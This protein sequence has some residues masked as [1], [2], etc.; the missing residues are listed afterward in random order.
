MGP[1]T[2]KGDCAGMA[3]RGEEPVGFFKALML[4]SP[5]AF[6]SASLEQ[7]C[8]VFRAQQVGHRASTL[9][10]M[11][12]IF[13]TAC[14]VQVVMSK[15]DA[16]VLLCALCVLCVSTYTLCIQLTKPQTYCAWWPLLHFAVH[17]THMLFYST[18]VAGPNA[19]PLGGT[20]WGTPNNHPHNVLRMAPYF[21]A[22]LLAS[23]G[24]ALPF[25]LQ[26]LMQGS[27]YYMCMFQIGRSCKALQAGL[28]AAVQT[29]PAS[30]PGFYSIV[31][32]TVPHTVPTF[33]QPL[34]LGCGTAQAFW[35]IQVGVAGV[36]VMLLDDVFARRLFLAKNPG[37]IGPNGAQR[38]AQ[39]PFGSLRSLNKVI[40]LAFGLIAADVLLVEMVVFANAR[41]VSSSTT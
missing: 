39:W 11:T 15:G 24:V 17:L 28:N 6:A 40:A 34:A 14:I 19:Q 2:G 26:V 4:Y 7:Q 41:V 5:F 21:G 27:V 37:L 38:A 30:V 10:T 36:A 23:I 13:W 32:S 18:V 25:L 22:G 1:L 8:N 3:Q 9:L 31:Q 33:L 29:Q 12:V 16:T 35:A 20:N